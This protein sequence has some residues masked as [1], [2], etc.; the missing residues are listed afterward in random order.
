[1][2]KIRI[3]GIAPYERLKNQ[4][5]EIALAYPS[6]DFVGRVGNLGESLEVLSSFECCDF[7]LVISRGGTAELLHQHID[8]PV[9]EMKLSVYDLLRTF[10]LV[11]DFSGPHAV[12]GFQG[13]TNSAYILR[14][15][16]KIDMEVV[17][18]HDSSEVL[19]M[20]AKL[21][22]HGCRMVIGDM[23]TCHCAQQ[24][25]LSNVLITSGTESIRSA[26]DQAI[27]YCNFNRRLIEKNNLMRALLRNSQLAV[28][29]SEGKLSLHTLD[30]DA[31]S[32]LPYIRRDLSNASEKTSWT[33]YRQSRLSKNHY[34]VTSSKLETDQQREYNV[35]H[36]LP[37]IEKSSGLR[38]VLPD[39]IVNS[40][41]IRLPRNQLYPQE[42]LTTLERQ[43][44][45]PQPM[46][47][48]GEPGVGKQGLLL[49]LY[50]AS[51]LS[52]KPAVV[53]DCAS[54]R[55]KEWRYLFEHVQSPLHDVGQFILF[56]HCE[57]LESEPMRHL[58]A[59]MENS[60]LCSSNKLV[61]VCTQKEAH[62]CAS[63]HTALAQRFHLF[64]CAVPPLRQF[65]G[66]LYNLISLSIGRFNMLL[67]KQIIGMESGA[68][69]LMQ[70]FS[71]PGN[72]SQFEE[73]L[74]RI[75]LTSDSQMLTEKLIREILRLESLQFAAE[76]SGDAR[77]HL[78]LTLAE[79]T[80]HIL[81]SVLAQENDN[82]TRAAKRLGISRSTLWRLLKND[83]ASV[84]KDKPQ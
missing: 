3:L 8:L 32:I 81:F 42:L 65:S 68:V 41:T 29:N 34:L 28:F 5:A 38:F 18:V 71:W 79:Q 4:M 49:Q 63:I 46:A 55:S 20:L 44:E 77:L 53:I 9:I 82:H 40:S 19:P 84:S 6:I 58:I 72:F 37:S 13:I 15:L 43:M 70:Q 39:E 74:Q 1:M 30:E 54:M 48:I 10:H 51:C 52:E 22:A 60:R 59:H 27:Q 66:E 17:T 21:K 56:T 26:F 83:A 2:N 35:F 33:A 16:L 75:M 57:H 67:G 36:V 50:A 69:R 61:F 11:K 25:D 47:V 62:I 80:R 78:H 24:I 14:D 12:V 7:D 23:L 73:V 31:A 45:L 76:E 64:T